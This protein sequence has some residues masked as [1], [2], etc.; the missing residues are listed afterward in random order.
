MIG[1]EAM[2]SVAYIDFKD[3]TTTYPWL[4]ASL[5]CANLSSPRIVDGVAKL[6]LKSDIDKVKAKPES[7]QVEKA[8]VANWQ[9]FQQTGKAK[10]PEGL[11]CMARAMIRLA[12]HLCKQE[13]KGRDTK[14]FSS[15]ADINQQFLKECQRLEQGLAPVPAQEQQNDTIVT[16][17][18]TLED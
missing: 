6:L 2:C 10:T 18:E 3:T 1:E 4:R 13:S 16:Q 15:I 7:L 5:L 11:S 14:V 17:P 8:I 12:L 9:L